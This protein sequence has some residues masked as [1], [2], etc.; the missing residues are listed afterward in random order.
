[1]L[2]QSAASRR[3][4]GSFG[5]GFVGPHW[6]LPRLGDQAS[7][8]PRCEQILTHWG[9]RRSRASIFEVR[10]AR[11]ALTVT[12]STSSIKI[13]AVLT[14][15]ARAAV[16]YIYF[17]HH[18]ILLSLTASN[19]FLGHSYPCSFRPLFIS[20]DFCPHGH[21]MHPPS[22]RAVHENFLNSQLRANSAVSSLSGCFAMLLLLCI[23]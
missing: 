6:N 14:L 2:L 13:P 20:S 19:P 4:P 5:T 23:C 22:P 18:E 17:S 8:P 10:G 3:R 1:M 21:S 9:R 11:S 12:A 16:A 7:C 15:S